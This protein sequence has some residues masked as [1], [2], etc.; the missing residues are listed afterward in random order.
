MQNDLNSR[1]SMNSRLKC[2]ISKCTTRRDRLSGYCVR[3]TYNNH[4]YGHAEHIKLSPKDLDIDD[5]K[6]IILLNHR[7]GHE[8]VINAMKFYDDWL[9]RSYDNRWGTVCP[10]QIGNLKHK[11]FTGL[12]LLVRSAAVWLYF[13]TRLPE[14][15]RSS[16]YL[17][18][19]LGH[20]VT[21]GCG[22]RVYGTIR[23]NVGDHIFKNLRVL[24]VSSTQAVMQKWESDNDNLKA[25]YL[26][27]IWSEVEHEFIE[28]EEELESS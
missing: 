18:Y 10:R 26:P 4:H 14:R 21:H 11:G 2:K 15:K 7:N 24:L 5:C 27:L 3:H 19:L 17:R 22:E 6:E 16:R 28:K 23:K 20:I 9:D 25:Q 1:I 8:G 12:D 13:N